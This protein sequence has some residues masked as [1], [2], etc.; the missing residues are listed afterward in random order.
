[1]THSIPPADLQALLDA[2]ATCALIDVRE[3]G[4]YNAAH[5]PGASSVPRRLLEFRMRRL[6]PFPGTTVLVY[7]DD[8]RRA[9]LAAAAL[10]RS[11]YTG[12]SVVAGGINRWGRARYPTEWDVRRVGRMYKRLTVLAANTLL[13]AVRSSTQVVFAPP[14]QY[15]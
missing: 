5:I 11:G 1:M 14:G 10:E 8:G 7:D 13:P 4:E 9:A 12:V 3:P 15:T 6:V 2:R